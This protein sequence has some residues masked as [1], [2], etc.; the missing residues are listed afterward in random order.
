MPVCRY[1]AAVGGDASRVLGA[2]PSS[3][4][5]PGSSSTSFV[6]P[7]ALARYAHGTVEAS[8]SLPHPAA[9][10]PALPGPDR[11]RH[12]DA[13]EFNERSD[14]TILPMDLHR[15]SMAIAGA[16]PD[17]PKQAARPL[18]SSSFVP[19]P[20]D[21]KVSAATERAPS[22]F[23]AAPP[24][25]RS[26]EKEAA[27]STASRGS[28]G[29]AAGEG[30]EPSGPLAGVHIIGRTTSHAVEL[31]GEGSDEEAGPMHFASSKDRK[32]AKSYRDIS[33]LFTGGEDE[34]GGAGEEAETAAAGAAAGQGGKAP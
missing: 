31:Q 33:S 16:N 11:F 27:A 17:S 30:G 1:A 22:P 6:M 14:Y 9:L 32:G 18:R 34:E 2:A 21:F 26:T 29:A 15:Y 25:R 19:L 5:M 10:H 23:A 12:S 4:L 8:D 24:T 3:G 7:E 28:G 13:T 20:A